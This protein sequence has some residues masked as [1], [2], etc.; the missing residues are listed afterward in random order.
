M[1]FSVKRNTKAELFLQG[2]NIFMFFEIVAETLLSLD[3]DK[4]GMKYLC[5]SFFSG[6]H[7]TALTSW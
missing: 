6:A 4:T 7:L 1:Y 2:Q 3:A 5:I